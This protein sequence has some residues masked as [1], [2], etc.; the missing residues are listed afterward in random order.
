MGMSHTHFF[1]ILLLLF[2]IERLAELRSAK[3]NFRSLLER[4]G[5]EFGAAHYPAI[6]VMHVAF[7]T[8]LVTEF[9]LRGA[10]LAPFFLVPLFLLTAAQLLRLWARRTMSTRWTARIV[11]IPG[12]QLVTK[13][14]FRFFAHPIYV[15]VVLE[16]FSLPL[17]FG[18]YWTC[19]I[20]SILNATMLLFIRIPC[21]RAALAW[22]Q[23]TQEN[24]VPM[25]T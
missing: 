16:L 19:L 23:A 3:R 7:F 20:F 1:W 2:A 5:R 24:D 13:G 11:V 18:L 17:I 15:A 4:G 14:P 22:S 12:E 10:P 21:E 8:S 25:E 9:V 6:V